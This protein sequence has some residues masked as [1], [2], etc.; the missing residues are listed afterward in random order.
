MC[1]PAHLS[2]AWTL[3]FLLSWASPGATQ[4]ASSGD[5]GTQP[6]QEPAKTAQGADYEPAGEAEVRARLAAIESILGGDYASAREVLEALLVERYLGEASAL[7]DAGI[8]EDGLS[9]VD[10]ALALDPHNP[11]SLL[12]KARGSLQL[13]AL[14]LAR[15]ANGLHVESAFRD[16]LKAARRADAHPAGWFAASQAA[17]MLGQAELALQHAHAGLALLEEA[18]SE[19]EMFLSPWRT[20]AE[21]SFGAYVELRSAEAPD[22]ERLR[23]LFLETEDALQRCLGRNQADPWT[24][25]Q[26]GYL[27]RWGGRADDATSAF[28]RGLDRVPEDRALLEGLHA[29]A[30]A[31]RGLAHA[32][33]AVSAFSQRHP[34]VAAG[35]LVEGRARF[36]QALA[37][38]SAEAPQPGLFETAAQRFAQARAM[39]PELDAE[40]RSYEVLCRSG[41][42]WCAFDAGQLEAAEAHFLSMEEFFPE[43]LKWRYQGADGE[44]DPLPS[45][46]DGLAWIADG[47]RQREEWE[48]AAAVFEI[49]RGHEPERSDWHNNTGFFSRD[50]GVALEYLGKR[51]CRAAS[52]ELQETEGLDTLRASLGLAPELEGTPTELDAFGNASE[53]LFERARALMEKSYNAYLEAALLTPEDVRVLNDT[54]LVLVYYLHKD[55]NLAEELLMRCVQLGEQ[56]LLTGELSDDQRWELENAWGDA[57]QNLGV[58]HLVHKA[59]P[60]A[61]QRFFER[62]MEIGPEPRP[63]V[64]DVWIGVCK[65]ELGEQPESLAITDWAQPCTYG[66]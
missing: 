1:T 12:L 9:R 37:A 55:L 2:R 34:D 52:G 50:A 23:E 22:P 24:W 40:C 15:D 53:Q 54:A 35:H 51:L 46:I 56:Q 41:L 49:L 5:T 58:L 16:A 21:A 18:P 25:S 42:G 45:G 6:S 66:K 64:R 48:R 43:G 60:E 47:W 61:A 27:Y 33:E 14:L 10:Q 26:L 3:A 13:G 4:E 19:P 20:W 65:G 44:Q 62:A 30:L 28:R 8:P 59:D 39:S 36:E 63:L 31:S 38:R 57:F 29:S 11:D 32:V 17:R 7:M